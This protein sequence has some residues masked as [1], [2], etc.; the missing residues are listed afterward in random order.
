MLA[1]AARELLEETNMTAAGFEFVNA[2]NDSR[3]DGAHYV[4]FGFAALE[5]TG[6]PMLCEP[7]HC[8]GWEWFPLDALPTPLFVGHEKLI[9]GFVS[10]VQ[11]SE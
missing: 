4:H 3:R 5:P 9:H 7:D 1:C 11:F 6:E 2:D 10:G 8:Y